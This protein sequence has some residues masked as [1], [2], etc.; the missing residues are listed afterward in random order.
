LRR[1][2]PTLSATSG[3]DCD[4]S[5]VGRSQAKYSAILLFGA[6]GS[7]KGTQGRLLGATPGFFHC[8]CG[9]VFRTLD[10]QSPLGREFMDYS[11]RGELVPDE[12]TV[13]LWQNRLADHVAAS[14]FQPDNQWLVLDGIP[15]NPSQSRMMETFIDVSLVIHL[16][17][18]DPSVLEQRLGRRAAEDHRHDDTC[19]EVVRRRLAVFESESLGVLDCY[20]RTIARTVD[21]SAPPGT[22]LAEILG[23]ILGTGVITARSSR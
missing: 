17:C 13:R 8:A 9:D 7:G 5:V 11:T 22:V 12:L 20:P 4:T 6:P 15:R 3:P 10:V 19:V 1:T 16:R 21:A 2:I 23:H 14:T 18:E